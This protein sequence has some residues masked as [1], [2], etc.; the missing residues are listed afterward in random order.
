MLSEEKHFK[1]A[2][3]RE[4]EARRALRKKPSYVYLHVL[5]E[6][7]EPHY[8]GIGYT[9]E[10][11]WC[12]ERNYLHAGEGVRVELISD[13]G[14]PEINFSETI[15]EFWEIAWIKALRNAGYK[16]ANIS[17]GGQGINIDWTEDMRAQA[18]ITQR[19]LKI[20]LPVD[21]LH[22]PNAI[23]KRAAKHS[24]ARKGKPVPH[25][26]TV[27][28]RNKRTNTLKELQLPAKPV[29]NLVTGETFPSAM[30]A[31]RNYSYAFDDYVADSCRKFKLG[32]TRK[33]RPD[34]YYFAYIEDYYLV[35]TKK[36]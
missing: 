20:G 19:A 24:A 7:D 14:C 31:A 28:C 16:L 36:D 2:W 35:S 23:K 17:N 15:A 34:G 6:T 9:V 1:Q 25:L 27:V 8:V 10:R 5:E 18:S 21:F 26:N 11:P 4:Q 22:T 30:A 32:K 13:D 33:L 29:I 12:K 3:Q